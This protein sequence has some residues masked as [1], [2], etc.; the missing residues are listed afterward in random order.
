MLSSVMICVV[1]VRI[2]VFL[3][4]SFL[5]P[6]VPQKSIFTHESL[7]FIIIHVLIHT[8]GSQLLP[9]V[10]GGSYRWFSLTPNFITALLTTQTSLP[11]PGLPLVSSR[12]Y[13]DFRSSGRVQPEA[14]NDV[15]VNSGSASLSRK[16]QKYLGEDRVFSPSSASLS[17]TKD[18]QDFEVMHVLCDWCWF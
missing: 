14:A 13:L 9:T 18:L 16:G 7:S 2:H 8:F 15:P 6:A 3:T 5:S 1:C 4:H 12:S 17:M 10:R 11:D